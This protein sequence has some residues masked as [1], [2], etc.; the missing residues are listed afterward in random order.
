MSGELVYQKVGRGM[1]ACVLTPPLPCVPD[2]GLD[3]RLFSKTYVSKVQFTDL[4]VDQDKYAKIEYAG[5]QLIRSVDPEGEFTVHVGGLCRPEYAAEEGEAAV[6]TLCSLKDT[7]RLGFQLFYERAGNRSLEEAA[8]V[9]LL[10]ALRSLDNVL[11]GLCVMTQNPTAGANILHRDL[12]HANIVLNT[13]GKAYMVDYSTVCTAAGMLA[14]DLLL[15]VV[16]TMYPPEYDLLRSILTDLKFGTYDLVRTN[17]VLHRVYLTDFC[18]QEQ[19]L[20]DY[21]TMEA[22]LKEMLLTL[23]GGTKAVPRF[24]KDYVVTFF[25]TKFDIFSLGITVAALIRQNQAQWGALP[26]T[27]RTQISLWIY[28]TTCANVH[29]R[30]SP[31]T[32]RVT[33]AG[34]WGVPTTSA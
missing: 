5:A 20:L 18:K 10:A 32:A 7:D 15:R 27:L 22:S 4:G 2:S 19:T 8:K 9:D 31:A 34:V 13:E 3:A 17:T 23:P 30:F 1:N 11:Y 26:D 6:R 28:W 29:M 14:D 21:T 24:L 33:W 16:N 25:S 12:K